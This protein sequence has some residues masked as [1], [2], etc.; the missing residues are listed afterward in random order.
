MNAEVNSELEFIRVSN[1]GI[2]LPEKVVEY[3]RNSTTE[4]HKHFEWDDGEAAEKYRLSQARA[5]IR[6]SVTVLDGHNESVRA[7]VSLRTDRK[8]GGGYRSV[9]DVLSSQDLSDAM[10][11]DAR[12]EM[13]HFVKKYDAI[14]K[15][16][17]IE[18]VFAAINRAI[19][20]D[21]VESRP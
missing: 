10:L 15:L 11:D 12:A 5:L 17:L 2:L 16:P 21:Q 20:A 3:A 7:F 18:P 4:I 6:V 9:V 14:K 8:Q 1:G 13:E 19:N